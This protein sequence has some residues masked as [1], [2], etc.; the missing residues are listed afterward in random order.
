MAKRKTDSERQKQEEKRFG[1]NNY[2]VGDFLIR[3]KNAG[4]ARQ[5]IVEVPFTKLVR[6]VAKILEREGYLDEVSVKGGA[7]LARLKYKKK[8]PVLLNIHLVSRP[9]LRVYMGVDAL[10][11]KKGPSIFVVS[12]PQG[13]VMSKDAIKKRV[14]GEVIAEIL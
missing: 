1:V 5:R 13:I 12:T 11:K 10:A 9:G 6:D 2:P 3:L 14:G 7:V 4:L 8:E